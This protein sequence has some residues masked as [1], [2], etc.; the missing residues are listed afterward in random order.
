MPRLLRRR[1]RR[2]RAPPA[3]VRSDGA[4]YLI[5]LELDAR[6]FGR[7]RLLTVEATAAVSDGGALVLDVAPGSRTDAD[8]RGP[9][10]PV[11]PLDVG[12]RIERTGPSLA[13][14]TA[15]VREARALLPPGAA[16]ARR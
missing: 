2:R 4:G 6:L 11:S 3:I 14:A 8:H 15:L 5:G 1:P 10:A 9:T 16:A 12:H 13:E 7:I